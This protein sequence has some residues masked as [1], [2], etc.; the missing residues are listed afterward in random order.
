[1]EQFSG[2]VSEWVTW[3]MR[4]SGL[5]ERVALKENIWYRQIILAFSF[6]FRKERL[7]KYQERQVGNENLSGSRDLG[8]IKKQKPARCQITWLDCLCTGFCYES[9]QG[10]CGKSKQ[11]KPPREA[12]TLGETGEKVVVL[13]TERV[14]W[15]RLVAEKVWWPMSGK[16]MWV[17]IPM[18]GPE[19]SQNSIHSRRKD[20]KRKPN[21]KKN[22]KTFYRFNTE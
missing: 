12:L 11:M 20:K 3:Q 22:Y 8:R 2:K 1:M 14:K 4:G 17:C 6:P 18:K 15:S 21:E 13:W 9:R 5:G 19:K 7:S 16:E 10:L